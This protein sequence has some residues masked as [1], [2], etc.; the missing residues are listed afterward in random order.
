MNKK[1][2]KTSEISAIFH[3][4]PIPTWGWLDSPQPQRATGGWGRSDHGALGSN[5]EPVTDDEWFRRTI[6]V[7][8]NGL[9]GVDDGYNDGELVINVAYNDGALM[10]NVCYN[11]WLMIIND[12][13]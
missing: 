5:W 1:T 8:S 11:W 12:D 7:G 13:W 10:I 3:G 4:V 9:V 2:K 6:C